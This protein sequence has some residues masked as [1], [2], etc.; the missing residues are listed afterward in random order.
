[1]NEGKMKERCEKVK[2]RKMMDRWEEKNRWEWNVEND[3]WGIG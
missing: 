1:M 2:R 3:E